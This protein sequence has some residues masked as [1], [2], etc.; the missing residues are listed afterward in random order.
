MAVARR[1]FATRHAPERV[2]AVV[3]DLARWGELLIIDKPEIKGFGDRF[4]P[5]DPPRAGARVEILFHD[6]LMQVW[7]V[8]AWEPCR[9]LALKSVE[10][11]G[12]GLFSIASDVEVAVEPTAPEGS[13]V[14]LRFSA[15]FDHPWT[16]RL[17]ER[18]AKGEA[19][20]ARILQRMEGRILADLL[21]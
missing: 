12:R 21:F 7:E 15:R 14:K 2:W 8:A 1:D 19:E 5:L 13:S 10:W 16:G 9:R 3:S 20:L 17:I 11:H 6:R 4:R 18:Y